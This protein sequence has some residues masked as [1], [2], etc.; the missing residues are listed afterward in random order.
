MNIFW[1]LAIVAIVFIVL[2]GV[3]GFRGTGTNRRIILRLLF[4]VFIGWLVIM[5]VLAVIG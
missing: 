3:F 2:S 1:I 5:L 4:W